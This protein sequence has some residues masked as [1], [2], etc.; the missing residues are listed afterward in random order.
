MLSVVS[1][2]FITPPALLTAFALLITYTCLASFTKWRSLRQFP[3][4]LLAKTS[5]A[6]LFWHSLHARVNVAQCE[7]LQQYGKH[8]PIS[9]SSPFSR[10]VLMQRC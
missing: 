6:W 3:G 2:L 8:N 4:P 7:A 10:H 9:D 1:S 5:R